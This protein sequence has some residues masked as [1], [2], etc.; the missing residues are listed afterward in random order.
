MEKITSSLGGEGIFVHM[1]ETVLLKEKYNRSRQRAN[2]VWVIGLYDTCLQKG[3]V[4]R[5]PNRKANTL[6]PII[7]RPVG[8]ESIVNTDERKGYNSLLSLGYSSQS[9]PF[10]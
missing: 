6:I 5:I 2:N 8:Q 3:F 10:Q 9:G 4:E 7:T 1:N